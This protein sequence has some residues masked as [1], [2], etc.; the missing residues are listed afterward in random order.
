MNINGLNTDE[1]TV[2]R[3]EGLVNTVESSVSRSYKD[4]F[5][6]NFLNWFNLVLIIIG[7]LLYI[8]G[9]PYSALSATGVIALNILVSTVQ[10]VKAKRR[11]DK[12]AIT[13][14]PKVTVIR[15]GSEI[16]IDQ[17]EIVMDDVIKI[18]SGEIGRAS[19]RERV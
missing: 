19:C 1:V 13:L 11:L 3:A 8:A 18:T 14:R 5:V 17:S 6:E 2:R 10:E 15:N 4:I 7:L 9:D 12:I 16:E